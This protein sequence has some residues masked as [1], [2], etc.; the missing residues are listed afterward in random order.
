MELNTLL[1]NIAPGEKTFLDIIKDADGVTTVAIEARKLL[2][3]EPRPPVRAESPARC[4]EFFTAAALADY[5]KKYGGVDTVVYAD[6]STETISAVLDEKATKGFEVVTMKPQIHPLW[7]PWADLGR[8]IPLEHFAAFVAQNRRVIIEPNGKELTL[9]LSQVRASV[10]VEIQRGRGKNAVN[11]VMVKTKIQ[12]QE[13]N[14]LVEIPDEITLEVPLY[15]GLG[16]SKIDIDIDLEATTDGE[17]FVVISSGT[18]AEA[19]VQAFAGMVEELQTALLPGTV[20]LGRPKH[21]AWSYL[22]ELGQ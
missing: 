10:D 11:G 21:A 15:I 1:K 5:L 9:L 8:K 18:V 7:K 17:V 6:P 22:K 19:R 14:E 12:G 20:T 2:P 3:E 16:G 4:H 13:K